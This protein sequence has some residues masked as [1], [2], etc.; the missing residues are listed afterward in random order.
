MAI[1]G[2]FFLS[3]SVND[4]NAQRQLTLAGGERWPLERLYFLSLS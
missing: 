4:T 1:D 3:L 2:L